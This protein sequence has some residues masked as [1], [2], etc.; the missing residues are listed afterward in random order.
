MS[1][2]T[3]TVAHQFSDAFHLL[4]GGLSTPN[5]DASTPNIAADTHTHTV[6]SRTPVPP[7][8]VTAA[9]WEAPEYQQPQKMGCSTEVPGSGPAAMPPSC[10]P[11]GV[12]SSGTTHPLPVVAISICSSSSTIPQKHTCEAACSLN[13][14]LTG[15]GCI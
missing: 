12:I 13:R 1:A 5:A 15:A 6:L 9:D 14:A 8:F 4:K 10:V 11:S 2:G 7:V 3:G